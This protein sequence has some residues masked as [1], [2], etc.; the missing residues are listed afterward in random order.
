[1]GSD[2]PSHSLYTTTDKTCE[3]ISNKPLDLPSLWVSP[4]EAGWADCRALETKQEPRQSTPSSAWQGTPPGGE[5]TAQLTTDH[6]FNHTSTQLVSSSL[7]IQVFFNDLFYHRNWPN[8][9]QVNKPHQVIEEELTE[10]T[11]QFL[12][13]YVLQ[14]SRAGFGERPLLI[15]G[16]EFASVFFESHNLDNHVPVCLVWDKEGSSKQDLACVFT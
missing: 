4:W 13:A 7:V 10:Q 14:K 15:A 3:K 2:L 1:M 11:E 16:L 5:R 12:F 9:M 6:N 8:E